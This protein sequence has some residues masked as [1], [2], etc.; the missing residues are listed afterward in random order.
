MAP[1]RDGKAP[2][3]VEEFKPTNGLVI[4]Y[5]T[6]AVCA[7]AVVYVA[8]SAHSVTGLRVALGFAVGGCVDWVVLLRP[9]ATADREML[10]LKN[11]LVDVDIPL[12]LIDGV[13]V[14]QTLN[15][16]VGKRRYVCAG[17]GRSRRRMFKRSGRRGPGAL[18]GLGKLQGYAAQVNPAGEERSGMLYETY[19][20][21][22][23]EELAEQARQEPA[24]SGNRVRHVPAWPALTALT[25]LVVAFVVALLF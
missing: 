8:V 21:T 7:L 22:R 17:I 24:P 4:G 2:A 16:W 23:I 13:T 1:S 5:V 9:R 25:A 14:R 12:A 18:L 20:A 11:S 3:P 15:V 6:L 19:V 10:R